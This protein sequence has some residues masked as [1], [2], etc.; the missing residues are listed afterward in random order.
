MARKP[1][2]VGSWWKPRLEPLCPLCTRPIP[3][4][5]AD[6]HHLVPRLKGGRHT[7]TLHRICHR[8][9]HALFTE[10]ELAERYNSAES[11]LEH[12]QMRKFVA[13]VRTKPPGFCESVK[14]SRRKKH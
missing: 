3:S 13:W 14:E 10:A 4:E 11:L 12:S 2:D 6:E 7:T 8:Q 1:V 5:Q 9:V